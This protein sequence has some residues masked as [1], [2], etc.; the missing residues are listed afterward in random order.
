MKK[1]LVFV[2]LALVLAYFAE[3]ALFPEHKG[4]NAQPAVTRSDA[5]AM[6]QT[7][8]RQQL[9]APSTATFPPRTEENCGA[10]KIGET[11]QVHS[12]VDSQNSFGAMIRSEYWVKMVYDPEGKTWTLT[13]ITIR[14]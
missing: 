9:K 10:S 5:C 7:F 4:A 3:L 8:V 14:P 13:E 6:S 12:F 11:W 1:G 2:V